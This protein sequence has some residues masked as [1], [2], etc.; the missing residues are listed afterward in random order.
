MGNGQPKKRGKPINYLS[1]EVD[2]VGAGVLEFFVDDGF[3]IAQKAELGWRN[4]RLGISGGDFPGPFCVQGAAPDG[5]GTSCLKSAD[6]FV[7]AL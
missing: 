3:R 1:W 2:D 5:F 4:A 6:D 7:G